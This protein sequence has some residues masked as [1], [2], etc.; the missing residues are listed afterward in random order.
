MTDHTSE[1][2]AL[3][4]WITAEQHWLGLTGWMWWRATES[5]IGIV[6]V[7]CKMVF[8]QAP[9]PPFTVVVLILSSKKDGEFCGFESILIY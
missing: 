9:E 7:G 4:C 3:M 6:V 8:P 1:I 5:G 2:G